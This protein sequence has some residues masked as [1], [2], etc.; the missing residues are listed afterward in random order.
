M[1]SCVCKNLGVF[2]HNS[3]LFDDVVRPNPKLFWIAFQMQNTLVEAL[4][5]SLLLVNELEIV[6]N[7]DK[8]KMKT[9]IFG[10]RLLN[11]AFI[12]DS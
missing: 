3:G 7:L 12:Y 1:A 4:V 8:K 11:I 10:D 2:G 5:K 6:G 9:Y